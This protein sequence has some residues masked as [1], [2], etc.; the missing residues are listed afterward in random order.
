MNKMTPEQFV[1]EYLTSDIGSHEF[2]LCTLVV[3]RM[4]EDGVGF[5]DITIRINRDLSEADCDSAAVD[6]YRARQFGCAVRCLL[7]DAGYEVEF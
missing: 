1:D 5:H 4:S 7:I 2:G 3:E 6:I